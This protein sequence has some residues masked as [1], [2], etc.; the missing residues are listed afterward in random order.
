MHRSLTFVAFSIF[1][2]VTFAAPDA[3]ANSI[4][5]TTYTLNFTGAGTNPTAGSFTYDPDTMTFTSFSVTFGG[6]I[7]DLTS[8]ANAPRTL[9]PFPSCL[10]GLAGGAATF[11]FIAGSCNPP[12]SGWQQFW[13]GL[14]SSPAVFEFQLAYPGTPGLSIIA[15]VPCAAGCQFSATGAGHWS[16]TPVPEPR[17]ATLTLA[18]LLSIAFISRKRCWK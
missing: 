4:D 5:L 8:S 12:P 1:L 3:I 9:G 11:A 13:Q 10:D 18:G 2:G 16:A 14:T 6:L 15:E 17:A 7:F